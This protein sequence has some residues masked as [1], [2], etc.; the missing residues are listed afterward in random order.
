MRKNLF[1][2]GVL[3]LVHA[4]W[5]ESDNTPKP[6]SLRRCEELALATHPT[7]RLA[8]E[9]SR[10]AKLKRKEA[11]RGIWPLL[12]LKGEITEGAAERTL[13]TPDF[14]EES[15]GA[16][17]SQPVIQGGRL[18]NAYKQAR[19]NWNAIAAKEE[20]AK[21]E[22]LYGARESYWNLVKALLAESIY[23][24]ALTDLKA[25]RAMA[26]ELSKK[27]VISRQVY[28]TMMG[29]HEQAVLN[30][31]AAHADTVAR[32]W[33]WT[34][35]LGLN[36][37]PAERPFASIPSSKLLAPK[38]EECLREA[39][40]AH[41]DLAVQRYTTEAAQFGDKAGRG[42]YYPRLSVNG[43]YGRSGAAYTNEDFEFQEDW[44]L[45]AQ[46]SQYFGGSSLNA[47][48][49]EIKTS[50][51]LGQSTRTQ[52]RTYA[53][54]V[55]VEDSLKLK[56]EKAEAALTYDQAK[57][58]LRRTGMEVA[59]NVRSAY[60]EWAKMLSQLRIAETD[61]SIAKTEFD[62]ARIKSTNREVPVSERSLTRNRLAQAEVA[63]VDA[64]AQLRIAGAALARAIGRPY[65]LE[66]ENP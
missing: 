26:E 15:Y 51:K 17:L 52:T 37:P 49:Q 22:V 11:Y 3:I 30:R 1:F 50:P 58:D 60:A 5:A 64:Q 21:Q 61:F 41:P 4:V 12:T 40:A 63:W 48:A 38:L 28:L 39:S 54:S 27:E 62:V 24:K 16:Q 33:N 36:E 31:E 53:G 47:S 8:E 42:H 44:N 25:D 56:S 43:F 9:E 23:D 34:A 59:N 32:L 6:I 45:G 10:V 7:V 35:A 55:G 18:V 20:K 46:I 29:Q 19:A 66:K 13:G 2:F 65:T 14:L 57:E